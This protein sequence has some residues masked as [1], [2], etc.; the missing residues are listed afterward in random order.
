[1]V[2][3]EVVGAEEYDKQL[4]L[5][6]EEALGLGVTGVPVILIANK[7]ALTGAQS[8]GTIAGALRRA[9]AEA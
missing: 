7:Y 2:A 5:D 8:V 4:A 1:M 6:R 9:G 3:R